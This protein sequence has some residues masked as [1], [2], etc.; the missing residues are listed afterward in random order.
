MP[1][2]FGSLRGFI[3]LAIGL[4]VLYAYFVILHNPFEV[5][6]KVLAA[7]GGEKEIAK[8]WSPPW[9]EKI[10]TFDDINGVDEAREVS[11]S[12]DMET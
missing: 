3:N 2:L 8:E 11:L 9:G 5:R 4:A 10:V 7:I 6:Q 1:G 12:R